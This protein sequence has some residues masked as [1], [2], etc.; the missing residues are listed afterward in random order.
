MVVVVVVAG[1]RVSGG[2]RF[3]VCVVT[4]VV[5]V[6]MGWGRH[7]RSLGGYVGLGV[8]RLT[9]GDSVGLWRGVVLWLVGGRGGFGGRC[10]FGWWLHCE[11]ELVV[12]GRGYPSRSGGS[13]RMLG[14]SRRLCGKKRT[15]DGWSS[16]YEN[17]GRNE[18][19]AEVSR[20]YMMPTEQ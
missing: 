20:I 8:G 18:E 10:W 19:G 17:R 12:N 15:C 6:D 16:S 4:V 14:C 2:G 13:G 1:T 11:L 5:V 9:L 7:A 3:T